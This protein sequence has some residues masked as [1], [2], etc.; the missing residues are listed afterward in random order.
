MIGPSPHLAGVD[1]YQG[2]YVPGAS[3]E[4]IVIPSAADP[5]QVAN[6]NTLIEELTA[7]ANHASL[8]TDD[9]EL[10]ALAAKYLEDDEMI[11]KEL[12]LQTYVQLML[13]AKQAIA[14]RQALWVVA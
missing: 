4:S 2:V 13:T 14:R 12:D 8:P 5:L 11:D 9:L 6:L 10:M 7:F 3:I 1:A